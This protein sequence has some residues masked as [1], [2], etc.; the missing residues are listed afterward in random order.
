[1]NR[2]LALCT[3]VSLLS[4]CDPALEA[5]IEEEAP[6]EAVVGSGWSDQ[7]IGA[8]GKAGNDTL[9]SGVH[10]MTASGA[11]IFG[12]ADQFHFVYQLV[13]GNT[14]ITARVTSLTNTNASAKAVV[15]IRESLAANSMFVAS[16]LT[17]TATNKF[18]QQARTSTGGTATL[19]K[20]GTDSKLGA[21][22]RV[23]R[24]IDATTKVSTFTTYYSLD[25]ANWKQISTATMKMNGA[26]YVGIG[27][28]SHDNTKLTTA[29]FDKVGFSGTVA[30]CTPGAQQCSGNST[31]TC[32]TDGAWQTPQACANICLAGA[33]TVCTPDH[34][35]CKNVG[36]YY[37]CD[38]TGNWSLVESCSAACAAAYCGT[39]CF[40]YNEPRYCVVDPP[41]PGGMP[42]T[43]V[44]CDLSA[45]NAY[46]CPWDPDSDTCDPTKNTY[47]YVYIQAEGGYALN[48]TT[49]WVC[50]NVSKTWQPGS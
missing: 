28:T 24:S 26:A 5:E 49:Y 16:E 50:D 46:Y 22:L 7:D 42:A 40:N 11:D 44:A 36:D 4:A 13:A 27:A 21:Y 18:R 37:Q 19:Y 20:S 3:V 38:A 30:A 45:M 25:G 35:T 12:T 10:T 29:K 39:K 31:Q 6:A 14:T 9:S 15:M 2:P 32:S 41:D 33:C 23:K 47:L 17:P 48:T 8:V 1:M 34:F 43:A